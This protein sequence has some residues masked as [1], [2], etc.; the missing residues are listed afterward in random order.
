MIP[1]ESLHLL[2]SRS[3]VSS[4]CCFGKKH[5]KW[6]PTLFFFSRCSHYIFSWLFQSSCG[7]CV[8]ENVPQMPFLSHLLT[9]CFS[10]VSLFSV[11]TSLTHMDMITSLAGNPAYY[12][13][14]LLFWYSIVS[15]QLIQKIHLL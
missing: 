2:D 4:S 11:F 8:G 3:G 10:F 5:F 15:I 14:L 1:L 6:I 7:Y 13:S 9:T 12:S